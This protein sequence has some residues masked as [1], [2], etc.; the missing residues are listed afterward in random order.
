MANETGFDG[1]YLGRATEQELKDNIDKIK[2][3]EVVVAKDTLKSFYKG[4]DGQLHSLV[5]DQDLTPLEQGI[6]TNKTG[7]ATNKNNIAI[8]KAEITKKVSALLG[9]EP[10]GSIQDNTGTTTVGDIWYDEANEKYYECKVATDENFI[11]LAKWEERSIDK[12]TTE[13]NSN[14]ESIR[15]LKEGLRGKFLAETITLSKTGSKTFL[16]DAKY[17][18]WKYVLTDFSFTIGRRG[19]G[20]REQT[21]S[22]TAT[23]GDYRYS[24][25]FN[26][27]A[28]IAPPTGRFVH[29]NGKFTLS[30]GNAYIKSL[31][32]TIKVLFYK[33]INI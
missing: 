24:A 14:T 25:S 4:E 3:Y 26:E 6:N 21:S 23:N 16:H 15:L 19:S 13:I 8:N 30:Y 9:K 2:V 32:S 10:R 31:S 1:I 27:Y 33:Q 18:D 22:L 5:P 20:D 12:A 28:G 17:N 11:D 7:V 29:S